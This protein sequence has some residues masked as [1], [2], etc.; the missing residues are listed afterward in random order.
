MS[1][2]ARDI[3]GQTFGHLTAIHEVS[4]K[5]GSH[6]WEFMCKCG[7]FTITDKYAVMSGA[8]KM[9]RTCAYASSRTHGLTKSRIYRIWSGMIQRCYNPKVRIYKNYGGRGIEVCDRWRSFINFYE[10]MGAEYADN[11][12]IDRINNDGNY[13]PDNCRWSSR[14]EQSRN[15]RRNLKFNGET[16]IDASRRLGGSKSL[17]STRVLMGWSLKD[18]FTK[19][20]RIH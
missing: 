20:V 8:T 1:M 10:D 19:P 13:C 6:R 14:A 9:C 11:L 7:A 15:Y 16:A 12:S 5:R 17:V 2:K 18:A 3:T 4:R